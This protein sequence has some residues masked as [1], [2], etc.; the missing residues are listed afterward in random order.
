MKRDELVR[1]RAARWLELEVLLDD[2][3]AAADGE[4][5][6]QIAALYREL[7]SDLMRVRSLELG[8]DLRRRLDGLAAR[9]NNFLYRAPA[10]QGSW[11]VRQLVSDF[12]ALVREKWPFVL[13][14]ALLFWLPL[15]LGAFATHRIEGFAE[16]V[17]SAEMLEQM[18]SAYADG[19]SGGRSEGQ[20]SAMSGFYVYNNI[21]I[22]FRCFATGVL[23]GTGS[24]FFLV[25]N[26]LVTGAVLGH[27]SAVG[28]GRNILTFIS[29]HAAFEL[30]AIV[31]S[32]AAG[33]LLGYSL[34][35]TGGLSRAASLR[36]AGKAALGLMV[37]AAL[38]LSVAAL[39]EG[40]WSPSSIADPVKWTVGV[41][42]ALALTAYLAWGGRGSRRL[43]A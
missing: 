7:C 35:S 34:L 27:V 43:P 24:V 25:Y 28:H 26:G 41:A 40:F 3:R 22:A 18:S 11:M 4:S 30:T 19:F 32:G 38:L 6:R 33:L 13:V 17:L 20:N 12:P 36:R 10:K 21:G 39:V 23:F 1:A 31:I 9:A 8:P 15:A 37:G 42:N 16:R 29:G 2:P 14:A 5:V